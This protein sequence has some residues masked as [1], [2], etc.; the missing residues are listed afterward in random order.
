MR[1][2]LYA[3]GIFIALMIAFLAIHFNQQGSPE[4][5]IIDGI[6]WSRV[7][8]WQFKNGFYPNGWSWGNWSLTEWG[9]QGSSEGEMIVYFFPFTH[10]KDFVLET[11]VKFLERTKTRDVE[12]QLLTRDSSDIYCESG[13]VLF[14]S[15]NRV[16]IRYLINKTNYIY[17]TFNINQNISYNEW[18]IMRFLV[19]NGR[20]KAF[21]NDLQVCA[22]DKT[23]P[24]DG[25]YKQPHLAVCHGTAIF[26]YVKIFVP[27]EED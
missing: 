13:M 17:T 1:K 15:V 2:N 25:I 11:K 27:T 18:Y 7:L 20:I 9:L 6:S 4:R 16:T 5:I 3:L 14:A 10:G 12:A 19:Y 21:V 24:A 23:L 8:F 26:D 22:L